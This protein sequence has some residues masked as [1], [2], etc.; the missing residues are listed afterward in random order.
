MRYPGY[1]TIGTICHSSDCACIDI[2]G[3]FCARDVCRFVGSDS[4]PPIVA[5]QKTECLD[6]MDGRKFDMGAEIIGIIR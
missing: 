6:H 4:R 3:P 1:Y 5:S 2:S